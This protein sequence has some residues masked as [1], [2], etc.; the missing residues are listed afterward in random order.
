MSPLDMKNKLYGPI[1]NAYAAID[2]CPVPVVALVHG[3]AVGFGGGQTALG[4]FA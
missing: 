3:D 4:K 2:D 1:L